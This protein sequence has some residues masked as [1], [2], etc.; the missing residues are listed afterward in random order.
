MK[1]NLLA[2]AVG[3]AFI[4][5]LAAQAAPTVYGRLN[6]SVDYMDKDTNVAGV[7]GKVWEL[8]SNSSRVGVKGNEKLTDELTA[9][10]KAEWD[11]KGDMGGADLAGRERY[12]GLKHY[13][14]GTV[15][16]GYIDSPFKNSEDSVDVFN[17]M[18]NLDMGKFLYGQNRLANSI[19]YVSPKFLDV[20]G[21]NLTLQPGEATTANENHI[22]DAISL[23]LSYEDDSLYLSAAMDKEVSNMDAMRFVARYKMSDITLSAMFQTA[24]PTKTAGVGGKDKEQSFVLSGSYAM[25]KV[26]IRGE[27]LSVQQDYVGGKMDDETMLIGVGVDYNLTQSTKAFANLATGTMDANV[28]ATTTSTD[29]TYLGFGMETRF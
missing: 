20:F 9:V 21:A 16:L 3:V 15:R 25:D 11:V 5:P 14:W 26:A 28:G 17:D 10:Y 24:E 23:A 7:D 4:L 18:V 22:A 6:L 13:Q 1:R 29:A 2:L 27:I 19:N 12:I 8:N